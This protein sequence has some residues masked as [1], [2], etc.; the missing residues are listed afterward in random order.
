[1]ASFKTAKQW[2]VPYGTWIYLSYDEAKAL[3]SGAA[4]SAVMSALAPMGPYA[5]AAA[6]AIVA[7]QGYIHELN[8]KSDHK[9]VKLLLLWLTGMIVSVERLGFSP[10]VTVEPVR[11]YVI[12]LHDNGHT[13]GHQGNTGHIVTP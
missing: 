1:M 11:P 12:P 3:T 2:L 6:A 7:Q 4:I 5:V 13:T 10:G 8:E 9:G